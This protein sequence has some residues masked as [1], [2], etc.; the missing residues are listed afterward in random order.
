MNGMQESG[1]LACAKH[2]PGHGDTD[3]DSHK[4]LPVVDHTKARIDT[5]DL[6]PFKR[7]IDA[8]V[9]SVMVAHLNIP[10]LDSTENRASTLSPYVVDTMLRQQLNFSGLTFTDALNMKG[11][12]SF[13]ES[14]ALEVAAL[15]AGNDILL[16]PE[17]I[18]AAFKAIK[19][20]IQDSLL[21]EDR[22]NQSCHKILKAKEWLGLTSDVQLDTLNVLNRA[23]N[24]DTE[25]LIR[26][27]EEGALTLLKNTDEE[28][29][30]AELKNQKI[31]V[32][33]LGNS[34]SEAFVNQLKRYANVN[35]FD[36]GMDEAS[37]FD[38]LIISIHKS[39]AS[40]GNLIK[41]QLLKKKL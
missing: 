11:V 25:F 21:T 36:T 27:L 20:A 4:T 3:S 10:S 8:G 24:D 12:S 40:P 31:A 37:D 9:A 14:G 7:L 23:Q 1:V 26:R 19:K 41:L 13:Y 29:P 22:I 39:N 35:T 2:F 32:L 16:F 17:D 6:I 38:R 5:V 30:I 34:D 15:Q 28:I 18:P 33:T